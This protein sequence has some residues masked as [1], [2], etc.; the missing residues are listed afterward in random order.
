MPRMIVKLCILIAAPDSCLLVSAY[1]VG[2]AVFAEPLLQRGLSEDPLP[3][4][5]E[6][7]AGQPIPDPMVAGRQIRREGATSC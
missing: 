4:P 2:A 3:V 5:V 1:L 7:A 6:P